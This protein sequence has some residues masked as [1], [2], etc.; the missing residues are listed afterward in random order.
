M[1][2]RARAGRAGERWSRRWSANRGR[3]RPR[4][5]PADAAAAEADEV[6]GATA[7]L[8]VALPVVVLALI[9]GC[10]AVGAGVRQVLL[11]DAAADAARV[12]GRGDDPGIAAAVLERAAPGV[13][14]GIERMSGLV[15]VSAES[16]AGLPGGSR[17]PLR[18]TGCALDGGR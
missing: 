5:A 18:A 11:Q 16:E 8:A 13:R 6:G 2:A 7:E 15:C 1:T 9:L 10:G 17:V 14:M 12:L 4:S 3:L